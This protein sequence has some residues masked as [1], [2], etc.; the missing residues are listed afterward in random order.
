MKLPRAL[1]SQDLDRLLTQL[2]YRVTHQTGSH[3]RLTTQEH[4]EHHVTVPIH[5]HRPL[6]VGTLEAV[7]GEVA[8]H[9]EVTRA[10][11][12]ERLFGPQPSG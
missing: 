9:F 5:D 6:R 12:L 3:Q 10:E 7:L 8:R 11:L 4:G 2:G 1:T